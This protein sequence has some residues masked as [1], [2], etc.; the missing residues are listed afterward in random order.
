M[1]SFKLGKMTLSSLFKQPETILYPTV[2]KK[3]PAGLKGHIEND[4]GVCILCGICEKTC[5]AG[6]LRVDKKENYWAID[7]FRCVQ[8]AACTRACPK[9]CL[10]MRPSYMKPSASMSEDV[11]FK[12]A[13]SEDELAAK[14]ARKAA[15]LEAAMKAKAARQEMQEG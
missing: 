14:E 2:A 1:G 7:R 5:P 12:P 10:A 8:C 9:A 6:A 4:I 3:A 11:F 13:P 15:K